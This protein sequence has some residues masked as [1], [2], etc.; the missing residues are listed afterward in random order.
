MLRS[1]TFANISEIF[2]SI[3][4]IISNISYLKQ[5]ALDSWD[6]YFD[7][8]YLRQESVVLSQQQLAYFYYLELFTELLTAFVNLWLTPLKYKK[9]EKQQQQDRLIIK[10]KQIY[11]LV[12]H[13]LGK[14]HDLRSPRPPKLKANSKSYS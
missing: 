14:I 12:Y 9:V 11:L 1:Q 6:I 5:A 7:L 10:K 13:W 8:P 4:D 3:Y 2:Q